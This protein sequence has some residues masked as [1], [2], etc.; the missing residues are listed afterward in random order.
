[1]KGKLAKTLKVHVIMHIARLT[2][3][4]KL[5]L[6]VLTLLSEQHI[7]E[8]SAGRVQKERQN[9]HFQDRSLHMKRLRD[10]SQCGGD[11]AGG[12]EEEANSGEKMSCPQPP[13]VDTKQTATNIAQHAAQEAVHAYG[14][15]QCAADEVAHQ[16]KQ[17][18]ADRA[19]IA[20]KAAEAALAGKQQMVEQLESELC[21]SEATLQQEKALLASTQPHVQAVCKT[22]QL[23]QK[24]LAVL[25]KLMKMA[26]ENLA[27]ARTAMAGAEN[28]LAEKAARIEA[29]QRRVDSLNCLLKKARSELESIKKSTYKAICAAAEARQKVDRNRRMAKRK[30]TKRRQKSEKIK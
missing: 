18:L 25:Q 20:A 17:Q 7:R 12:D 4:L 11:N 10:G 21:E 19:L 15:Q 1:M 3:V 22:A 13:H 23:A 9:R 16:V 28:E 29:A 26:E 6:L 14:T 8:A 24:L 27:T 30:R 5:L 2:W